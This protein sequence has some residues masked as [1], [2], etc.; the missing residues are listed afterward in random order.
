MIKY[1][2]ILLCLYF[3]SIRCILP[4]QQDV[5]NCFFELSENKGQITKKEIQCMLNDFSHDIP[6]WLRP[7]IKI[8]PIPNAIEVIKR[9]GDLKKEIISKE[10]MK[11]KEHQQTCFRSQIKRIF[12]YQACQ[13]KLNQYNRRGIKHPC[14]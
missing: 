1:I 3:L 6:N 5:M 8:V 11:S 10:T 4:S 7:L 2:F 9:C 13:L 12:G 14:L